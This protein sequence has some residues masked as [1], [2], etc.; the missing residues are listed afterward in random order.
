MKKSGLA[1]S[2]IWNDFFAKKGKKHEKNE[3]RQ[4]PIV[5]QRFIVLSKLTV[6]SR[7][8]THPNWTSEAASMSTAL[9]LPAPPHLLFLD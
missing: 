9:P 2:G 1:K 4:S 6:P 7:K 3:L 8:I 5:K